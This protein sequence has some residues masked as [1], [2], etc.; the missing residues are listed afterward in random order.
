MT[1][2]EIKDII[3]DEIIVDDNGDD[4]VYMGWYYFMVES[5]EFPFKAIA[6]IKKRNSTIEE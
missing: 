1:E 6:N 3:E 5:L 4:E 2:K